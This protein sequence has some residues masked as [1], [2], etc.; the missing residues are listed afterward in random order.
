MLGAEKGQGF[1][2]FFVFIARFILFIILCVRIRIHKILEFTG[3]NLIHGNDPV[4]SDS[5]N[6]NSKANVEV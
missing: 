3:L 6:E 2:I 5:D 4:N 1:L